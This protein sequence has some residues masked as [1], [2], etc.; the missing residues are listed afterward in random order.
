MSLCQQRTF[1]KAREPIED[2]EEKLEM[3]Q[4]DMPPPVLER[5][6]NPRIREDRAAQE[7]HLNSAKMHCA[8]SEDAYTQAW[9]DYCGNVFSTVCEKDRHKCCPLQRV[10]VQVKY[11]IQ[12][13]WFLQLEE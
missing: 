3:R 13:R 1:Y 5:G 4:C 2:D 11:S 12:Q 7:F 10:N 9:F 6:A 8:T